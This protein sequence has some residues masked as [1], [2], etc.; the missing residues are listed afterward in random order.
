M[1][2]RLRVLFVKGKYQMKQRCY[3]LGNKVVASGS[4]LSLGVSHIPLKEVYYEA[5]KTAYAK[6]KA[7]DTHYIVLEEDVCDKC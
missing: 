3:N 5:I 4:L 6:C 1:A 2:K 7:G